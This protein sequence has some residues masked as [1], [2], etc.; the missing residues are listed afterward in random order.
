MKN[1]NQ[2]EQIC[3]LLLFLIVFLIMFS[4]FLSKSYLPKCVDTS[5]G[6]DMNTVLDSTQKKVIDKKMVDFFSRKKVVDIYHFSV[7]MQWQ[8][9]VRM[10]WQLSVRMQWQLFVR[11]RWQLF[12]R[13]QWQLF[14]RMSVAT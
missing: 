11:M 2:L 4:C 14:V 7:R 13:M 6:V 8:L 5:S 1:E 12:V 9:F 10:Q 3:F